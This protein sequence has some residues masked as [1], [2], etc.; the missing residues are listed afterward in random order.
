MKLIELLNFRAPEGFHSTVSA[1]ARK[2]GITF[3]EFIRRAVARS[4]AEAEQA[5]KRGAN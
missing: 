1:E 5:K 4:L 3:A 2:R